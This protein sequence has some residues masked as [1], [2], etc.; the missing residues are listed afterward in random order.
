MP[1]NPARIQAVLAAAA[2]GREVELSYGDNYDAYGVRGGIT[3]ET[4]WQLQGYREDYRFSIFI[5]ADAFPE[6]PRKTRRIT[7]DGEERRILGVWPDSI[8]ALIRL[9]V[10]GL[11][12]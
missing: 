8:G 3:A 4:E 2:A 9:D 10:G 1:P 6:I 7:V 5:A 11:N 12:A